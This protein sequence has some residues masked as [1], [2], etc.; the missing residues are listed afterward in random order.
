MNRNSLLLGVVARLELETPLPCAMTSPLGSPP[1]VERLLTSGRAA[2]LNA[3]LTTYQFSRPSHPKDPSARE[4]LLPE[5][6]P[7]PRVIP[8]I[9]V[10]KPVDSACRSSCIRSRHW[11]IVSSTAGSHHILSSCS[12]S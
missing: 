2:G 7:S 1:L 3:L 11:R 9:H 5:S 12:G 8:Y 10:G 6:V 4:P